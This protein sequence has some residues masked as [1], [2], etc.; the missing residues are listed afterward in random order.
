MKQTQMSVK[1]TNGDYLQLEELRI[2]LFK[3]KEVKL[4]KR[5]LLGWIITKAKNDIIKK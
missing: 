3:N 5:A 1:I 4:S 2:Y